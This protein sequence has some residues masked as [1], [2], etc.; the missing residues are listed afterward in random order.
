L[1]TPR[2][3]LYLKDVFVLLNTASSLYTHT[4]F[5]EVYGEPKPLLHI[6]PIDAAEH[7]IDNDD[8]VEICNENE[9][10]S[11][12]ARIDHSLIRGVLWVQRQ[13]KSLDNKPLNALIPTHTQAVGGGPVFNSTVVRINRVLKRTNQ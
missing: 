13:I 10:L 2:A 12:I 11:L 4:Q 1:P 3:E 6:N 8:I 7:G 5:R 9:C